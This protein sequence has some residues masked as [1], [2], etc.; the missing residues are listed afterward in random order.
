MSSLSVFVGLDV[1]VVDVD[2][3]VFLGKAVGFSADYDTEQ[4][5]ETIDVDVG[6][7]HYTFL[8]SDIKTI[9]TQ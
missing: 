8:S 2:D 5:E 4:G 3:A 7:R 1:Q 9:R 6:D